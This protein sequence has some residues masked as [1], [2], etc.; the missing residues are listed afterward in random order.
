MRRSVGATVACV[1]SGG[2]AAPV[3]GQVEKAWVAIYDG[4]GNAL[5]TAN[6]I[7][8]DAEGNVYVTGL[9][10]NSDTPGDTAYATVKYDPEGNEV[11]V[12]RFDT[13]ATEAAHA[14][15]VDDD[16][17]VVVTGWSGEQLMETDFATVKYDAD[18]NELW[19][20]HY[21]GPANGDDSTDIPQAITT[22]ALGNVYVTGAAQGEKGSDTGYTTIKYGPDG[23]ELWVSRYDHDDPDSFDNARAIAVDTEGNVYVTGQSNGGVTSDDYATVKYDK[24]G[25]ELWVRRYNG[26]GGPDS[27]RDSGQAI[28]VDNAGHVYITGESDEP[29]P[30]PPPKALATIKYDPDGNELWVR[31]EVSVAG[32]SGPQLCADPA[33][34][35]W[36]AGVIDLKLGGNGSIVSFRYDADGRTLWSRDFTPEEG[37]S[38]VVGLAVD[39]SGASY[40]GG[41]YEPGAGDLHARDYLTLKYDADGA[42]QWHITHDSGLRDEAVGIVVTDGGAC[43]TGLTQDQ[44]V[45]SS[46][47]DFQTVKYL[48]ICAADINADGTLNVLDFVAFQLLWQDQDPAADCDD[49]AQFNIL[50]FICFQQLFQTGCP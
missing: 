21:D 32:A 35:A 44:A 6:A 3:A 43:V 16:G 48:D 4:P 13:P 12:V 42:F 19:V 34:G 37:S 27:Q 36:V 31:R 20:R 28:G 18:G 25:N 10:R 38:F 2:L 33:G 24:E 15:A 47:R 22:D 39:A 45:G 8:A 50:D 9:S 14:I 30:Y 46:T 29:G 49:N 41:Y 26:P 17:N 7:A 11:W 23:D 40:V 5:D 1:A